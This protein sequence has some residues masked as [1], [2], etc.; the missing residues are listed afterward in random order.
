MKDICRQY[1]SLNRKE[2]SFDTDGDISKIFALHSLLKKKFINFNK[3]SHKD[4]SCIR[5]WLMHEQ[6]KVLPYQ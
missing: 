2:S 5:L 6:S 1:Y 4:V 3:L